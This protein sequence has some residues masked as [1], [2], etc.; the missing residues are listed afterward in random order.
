MEDHEILTVLKKTDPFE[1]LEADVL[2]QLSKK[3]GVKAY[4]PNSYA[5]RQ[6]DQSLD[7]SFTRFRNP[8]FPC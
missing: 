5:F 8:S 3:T 4:S 7:I 2:K 1:I 6:G